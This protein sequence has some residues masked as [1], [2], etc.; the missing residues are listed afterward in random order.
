[1]KRS[2]TQNGNQEA[3]REA[4]RN[5]YHTVEAVMQTTGL[6]KYQVQNALRRLHDSRLVERT[7]PGTYRT[8]HSGLALVEVWISAPK[9]YEECESPTYAPNE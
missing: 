9:V 2:R 1:M 7:N 8:K 4:V 5:G 6:R 3:V